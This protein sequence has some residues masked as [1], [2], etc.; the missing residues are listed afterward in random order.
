MGFLAPMVV[1]LAYFYVFVFVRVHLK[2]WGMTQMYTNVF[3]SKMA[4]LF[5]AK[6]T[7]YAFTGADFSMFQEPRQTHLMGE[8]G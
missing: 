6:H 3:Y 5:L 4:R 8:P 1:W 2:D 7:L